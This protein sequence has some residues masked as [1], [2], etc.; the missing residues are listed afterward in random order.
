[1]SFYNHGAYG[2]GNSNDNQASV[3]LAELCDFEC[4][5][6]LGPFEFRSHG[7]GSPPFET[8]RKQEILILQSRSFPVA[9]IHRDL[10]SLRSKLVS[11]LKAPTKYVA[12]PASQKLHRFLPHLRDTSCS[13]VFGAPTR[14][15]FYGIS[16]SRF[17]PYVLSWVYSPPLK[18][19]P[20]NP[21]TLNRC[22]PKPQT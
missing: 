4:F 5:S 10:E 14:T 2:Q 21:K 19:K 18:P 6:V 16:L 17:L 9:R 12:P 3:S 7:R 20:L 22:T 15:S 11:M 13:P 1:M 8:E